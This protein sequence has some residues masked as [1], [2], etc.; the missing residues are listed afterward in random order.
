MFFHI[1]GAYQCL[2]FKIKFIFYLD[3]ELKI[4]IFFRNH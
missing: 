1:F 3:D 4:I 2:K